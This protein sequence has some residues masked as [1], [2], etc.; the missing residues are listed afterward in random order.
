MF[1]RFQL[2]D[3]ID[4]PVTGPER[5]HVFNQYAIRVSG[6]RRDAL[7][8]SLRERQICCTVYYPIPLHL[9]QCFQGFGYQRGDFPEAETAAAEVLNL[10]IFPGLEAREQ[11]TV[12]RGIASTLD[13]LDAEGSDT[14]DLL[15]DAP[16]SQQRAA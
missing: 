14:I 8:Q 6:G 15:Q 12:V 9:Q 11:E 16:A 13:R 1:H 2:V 5:R 4:L 3:R 7:M 10:T